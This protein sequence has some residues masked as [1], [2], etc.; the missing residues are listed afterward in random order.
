MQQ[1]VL[2]RARYARASHS[3]LQCAAAA[4]TTRTPFNNP[5]RQVCVVM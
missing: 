1:H 3:K 2:G 4:D 5:G